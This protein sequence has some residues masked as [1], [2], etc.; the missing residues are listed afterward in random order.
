MS[1]CYG[2]F[3]V[4]LI[5]FKPRAKWL[6]YRFYFGPRSARPS[7]TDLP[8]CDSVVIT[9]SQMACRKLEKKR[10]TFF[11]LSNPFSFFSTFFP[12]FPPFG[13]KNTDTHGFPCFPHDSVFFCDDDVGEMLTGGCEGRVSCAWRLPAQRPGF[14]KSFRPYDL[15]AA[16]LRRAH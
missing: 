15:G 11:F 7:Y 9:A 16:E 12:F 8:Y 6:S 3:T 13:G 2:K 14:I 4:N 10:I 1:F 5:W